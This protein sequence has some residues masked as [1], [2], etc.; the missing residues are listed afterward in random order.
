MALI[1]QLRDLANG[2]T[3]LMSYAQY[4]AEEGANDFSL[5]LSLIRI[6]SKILFLYDREVTIVHKKR[7]HIEIPLSLP[8]AK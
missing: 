7:G 2:Y 3:S 6:P 8:T 5:G 1:G 4:K